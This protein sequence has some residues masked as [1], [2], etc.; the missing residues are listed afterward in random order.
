MKTVIT[1]AIALIFLQASLSFAAELP[2][3][4]TQLFTRVGNRIQVPLSD[5]SKTLN[6][7]LSAAGSAFKN[8]E[9]QTTGSND[10]RVSGEK[11][12]STISIRGPVS[13]TSDGMIKVHA[14]HIKKN[15]SGV[16][17]M[18]DLFGKELDDYVHVKNTAVVR[19]KGDNLLVRPD[20]LLHVRGHMT[21]VAL[22][23]QTLQ[24]T[25][26]SPPCR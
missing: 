26:S 7:R 5:L 8:V 9:L 19:V 3:C 10:I 18:M 16:K 12:G 17:S 13:A 2:A 23:G 25:F 24:L 6:Q 21:G 14:A 15:S 11:N 4:S 1:A 22:H 20:S